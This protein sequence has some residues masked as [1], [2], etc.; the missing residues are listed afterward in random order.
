MQEGVTLIPQVCGARV[1]VSD[2][3]TLTEGRTCSYQFFSVNGTEGMYIIAD[4]F[5]TL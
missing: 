4:Y 2:G 1:S 3:P 5:V